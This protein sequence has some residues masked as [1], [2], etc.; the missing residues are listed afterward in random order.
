MEV[1][2][3]KTCANGRGKVYGLSQESHCSHCVFQ[4]KWGTN[5]YVLRV[6]PTDAPTDGAGNTVKK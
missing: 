1:P 5:H 4:E 6:E 2:D 3:C